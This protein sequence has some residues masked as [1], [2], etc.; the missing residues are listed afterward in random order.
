MVD[1]S[2][3]LTADKGSAITRFFTIGI[4]LTA[5]G[6]GIFFGIPA[7]S[8][9][10]VKTPAK[11]GEDTPVGKVVGQDSSGNNVGTGTDTASACTPEQSD[12]L[13]TEALFAAWK[14]PVNLQ[15]DTKLQNITPTSA[16]VTGIKNYAKSVDS[17]NKCLQEKKKD[18]ENASNNLDLSNTQNNNLDDILKRR[19][20]DIEVAKDRAA[21]AINPDLNRSYYSGLFSLD[22]PMKESTVPI[23][24]GF[25]LFFITVTFLTVLAT[26]GFDV[27]ILAPNM[28]K[29]ISSITDKGK[30]NIIKILGVIVVILIGV[31]VFAFTKK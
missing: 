7:L 19:K 16:D 27:R 25:S 28:V 9:N 20:T 23:L 21:L 12:I 15:L 5:I 24:I 11:A 6:V 1:T 29:P 4:A 26:F 31:V 17:L 3:L 10:S 18:V 8:G 22:R 14:T 13:S 30:G 2:A